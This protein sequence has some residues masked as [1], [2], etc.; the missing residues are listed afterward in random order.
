MKPF[1]HIF[2]VFVKS[3]FVGRPFCASRSTMTALTAMQQEW[4]KNLNIH[5]VNVCNIHGPQHTV[6][7]RLMIPI[8]LLPFFLYIVKI[9]I[10]PSAIDL[11]NA[12]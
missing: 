10:C 7:I 9:G 5:G 3:L 4:M 6:E 11:F 1:F 8:L 12:L 2:S